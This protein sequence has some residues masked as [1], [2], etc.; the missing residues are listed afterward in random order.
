MKSLG[1]TIQT[2]AEGLEEMAKQ[3]LVLERARTATISYNLKQGNF[4][5]K[6]IKAVELEMLDFF[7][8]EEESN[9][10]GS[11]ITFDDLQ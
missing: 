7:D 8:I 5:K 9:G 11:V 3:K 6:M 2:Y 4:K 1:S 10:N